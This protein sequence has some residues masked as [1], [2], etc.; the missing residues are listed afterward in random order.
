MIKLLIGLVKMEVIGSLKNKFGGS[1]CFS[2]RNKR[3]QSR[4]NKKD[5]LILQCMDRQVSFL[6]DV[7]ADVALYCRNNGWGAYAG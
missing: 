5:F 7:V 4:V 1:F 2:G 3:Q 6:E